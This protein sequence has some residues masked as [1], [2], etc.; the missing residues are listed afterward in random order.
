VARRFLSIGGPRYAHVILLEIADHHVLNGGIVID[1]KHMLG[2]ATVLHPLV[3]Q[4]RGGVFSA[5]GGW[6]SDEG[7]TTGIART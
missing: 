7:T 4:R 3:K 2:S 6:K 1:H 5:N